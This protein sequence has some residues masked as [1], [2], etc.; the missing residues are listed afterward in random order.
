MLGMFGVENWVEQLTHLE[1]GPVIHA[2]PNT[3]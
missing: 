2:W 3:L 1:Y